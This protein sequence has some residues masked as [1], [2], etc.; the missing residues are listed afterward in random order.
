[1]ARNTENGAIEETIHED[2]EKLQNQRLFHDAKW[3]KVLRKGR[4]REIV[5]FI[6][7]EL[8]RFIFYLWFV[9]FFIV[10]L[11]LT[12]GFTP[13]LEE[14]SNTKKAVTKVFGNINDS[15]I[16]GIPP[17]TYVLPTFYTIQVVLIFLYSILSVFRAWIAKLENKISCIAFTLYSSIFGYFC[18][19]AAM[20]STIFSVQPDV[21]KPVTLFLH[22]LP[23]TNL[24]ISL[25]LLQVAVT[26]F[27]V[28]VS[29]KELKH[30]L[31]I[32][33]I[34]L[35][36]GSTSFLIGLIISSS[37]K[38]LHQ[39]NALGDLDFA[40]EE[41]EQGLWLNVH[42]DSYKIGLEV[43]DK[44]WLVMALLCPMIQSLYL[45]LKGL[46]T[47]GIIITIRDNRQAN[48]RRTTSKSQNRRNRESTP[49]RIEM[50][51]LNTISD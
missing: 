29:W 1:M 31:K 5:L 34:A 15:G 16:F 7:V 39:I 18:L 40:K 14:E 42:T 28:K 2:L 10:G 9:V 21:N 32:S 30:H 36:W 43:V 6:V 35:S 17:W 46:D 25:T 27:G 23:F 11:T 20:F 38:V 26:W 45:T 49:V 33:R 48:Q 51:D 22:T 12:H 50:D 37:L 19:S 47:H 3:F 4:E 41:I 13:Y 24:I 44:I 8:F